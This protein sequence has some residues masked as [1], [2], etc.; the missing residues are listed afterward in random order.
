MWFRRRLESDPASSRQSDGLR[1][2]LLRCLSLTLSAA[3]VKKLIEPLQRRT[4]QFSIYL[5]TI[6]GEEVGEHL[7]LQALKC[8]KASIGG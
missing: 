2:Q 7:I 3:D 6:L 8:A 5:L 1:P 4:L